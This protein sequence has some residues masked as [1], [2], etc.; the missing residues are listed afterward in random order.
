M[1][2]KSSLDS[3]QSDKFSF[4]AVDREIRD[5]VIACAFYGELRKWLK[6]KGDLNLKNESF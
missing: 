2:A 4:A 1:T 3:H 6:N 5:Q